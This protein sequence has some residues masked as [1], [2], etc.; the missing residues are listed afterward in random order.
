M[1]ALSPS[2]ESQ[3]QPSLL[4]RRKLRPFVIGERE[5]DAGYREIRPE[6]ELDLSVA[7]RFQERL[8]AA[9]GEDVEVLVCLAGCDFIDST[10]VAAIILAH[11]LM[12]GRGRRLF[13]CHPSP[14]VSRIL[15]L[16]GLTDEGLVLDA[17]DE[18]LARRFG[19]AVGRAAEL[20][21]RGDAGGA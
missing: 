12:V 2:P 3:D 5:L 7:D 11:K 17:D 18:V 1:S 8:N 10:G 19:H 15:A 13:I 6:G 9:A 14:E 16:T 21:S 20:P 4:P